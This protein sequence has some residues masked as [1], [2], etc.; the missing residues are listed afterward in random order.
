[1]RYASQ[2]VCCFLAGVAWDPTASA[3]AAKAAPDV[4]ATSSYVPTMTFDVASIRQAQIADSYTVSGDLQIHRSTLR[5]QNSDLP[6]LLR[7]AYGIEWY[8]MAGLPRWKQPAMFTIV[9]KSELA[10]DAK[11]TKLNAHD[12][13]LETRHMLQALLVDRFRMESHWE[14]RQLPTYVLLVT[15]PG[16]LQRSTG[17]PPTAADLKMWGDHPIPPLYQRNDGAGY[18]F[19]AHGATMTDILA[20]LQAQLQRAITDRTGLSGKYDFVLRYQGATAQ[21]E[22]AD[23]TDA[24]P[25]LDKA[26]Q[27]VLGLKV[28]PAKGPVQVLVVDHIERPSEN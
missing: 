12:A 6:N 23:A 5:L 21:D 18:D 1:M 28:E 13:L 20:M 9:A 8:Q 4:P 16:R 19:V 24:M 17:A 14:T 26:L 11:L 10:A 22:N 25:P 2:L 27:D 15:K 3:Q 7:A